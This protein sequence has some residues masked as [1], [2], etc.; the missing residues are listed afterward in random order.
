M[1]NK[2]TFPLAALLL[3][4]LAERGNLTEAKGS[5]TNLERFLAEVVTC[6]HDCETVN[7]ILRNV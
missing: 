5:E 3:P 7:G 2:T 4:D 1:V 6:K